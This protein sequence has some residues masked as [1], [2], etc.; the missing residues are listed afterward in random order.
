LRGEARGFFDDEEWHVENDDLAIWATA[1]V[2]VTWRFTMPLFFV[3]S[4]LASYHSLRSRSVPQ[5]L[6]SRVT[7]LLVPFLF[8]TFVVLI[9]V[10]VWME[11]IRHGLYEGSF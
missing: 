3:V 4:A 5:Y 11:R 8:G 1:F 2:Q 9:P 7:R 6:G 10:Q